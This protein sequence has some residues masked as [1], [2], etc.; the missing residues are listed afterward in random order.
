MASTYRPSFALHPGAHLDEK[1]EEL[2]MSQAELARRTGL[3]QKHISQLIAGDVSLSPRT[4]LLLE[5]TVGM[6]ASLWNNLESRWQTHQA[7]QREADELA[8][9]SEWAAHFPIQEMKKRRLL[10]KDA[11]DGPLVRQLLDFFGIGSIDAWATTYSNVVSAK[12]RTAHGADR[13]PFVVA[14]WL[15]EAELQASRLPTGPFDLKLARALPETLRRVTAKGSTSS[16]WWPQL[17]SH[18][19]EA[20]IALVL[21]PEYP[22]RTKLNG[23]SRWVTSTKGLIAL[24]G[25]GKRA[26][27]L[28][29]TLLHELGHVI[30]HQ[31]RR[32]F[33]N[34]EDGRAED[35]VEAEADL[36][37]KR[38][39]IPETLESELAAIP[40]N[41]LRAAVDFA[42][43]AGLHPSIVIGRLHHE[44][45][46]PHSHGV[47]VYCEPLDLE[48]PHWTVSGIA[49]AH[50]PA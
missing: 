34:L 46:L 13:S 43:G 15:R 23:A 36:F 21:V 14:T 41:S 5:H 35:A 20:G 42:E 22:P 3:S 6:P 45:R 49:D 28:W 50:Q 47:K 44:R 9:H 32:T 25:R 1:L 30:L 7:A 29:F 31:K 18:F 4:A 38:S 12:Y 39:L 10:T 16:H 37:A 48:H 33:I 2:G 26:D 11:Q 27:K 8:E 24:T 40:S 17:V 19:A